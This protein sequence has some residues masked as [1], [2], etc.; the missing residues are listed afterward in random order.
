MT[1]EI[2]ANLKYTNFTFLLLRNTGW[3]LPNPNYIQPSI[4]GKG[5]GNSF[6]ENIC[7]NSNSIKYS[8]S[9]SKISASGCYNDLSAVG[10][11]RNNIF[12]NKCPII[13]SISIICNEYPP[14]TLN[15][16]FVYGY[17]SYFGEKSVCHQSS[18]RLK[19]YS[20]LSI[21]HNCHYVQVIDETSY[22]ISIGNITITCLKAGQILSFD[23]YFIL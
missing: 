16:T 21:N 20:P 19:T 8:E 15:H 11:C 6:L 5:K 1:S 9:C 18:L 22:N 2:R 4:W 14:S 12:S 17:G 10:T 3:Y 13:D 23:G 7:P